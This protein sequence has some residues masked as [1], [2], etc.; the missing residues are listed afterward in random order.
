M[1]LKRSCSRHLADF[2]WRFLKWHYSSIDREELVEVTDLGVCRRS[3]WPWAHIPL[4]VWTPWALIMGVWCICGTASWFMPHTFGRY[5]LDVRDAQSLEVGFLEGCLIFSDVSWESLSGILSWILH[6]D[7]LWRIFQWW[8]FRGVSDAFVV[9]SGLLKHVCSETLVIKQFN[10][11]Y[12]MF[13][14]LKYTFANTATQ[15]M[16]Q[17]CWLI[18]VS[19]RTE[20]RESLSVCL[21]KKLHDLTWWI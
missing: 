5:R 19:V 14:H 2:I 9:M 10:I 8:C 16:H 12:L 11:V 17:C 15:E 1:I 18:W 7:E 21:P 4:E 20:F 13:S 3:Q 6:G